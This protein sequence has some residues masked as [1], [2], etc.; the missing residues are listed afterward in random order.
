MERGFGGT[1]TSPPPN[2]PTDAGLLLLPLN[3]EELWGN[4]TGG[5]DVVEINSRRE[6]RFAEHCGCQDGRDRL[7]C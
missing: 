4:P 1:R 3:I 6:R 2:V 7:R 5:R